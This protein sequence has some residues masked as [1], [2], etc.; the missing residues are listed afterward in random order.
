MRVQTTLVLLYMT[1][2]GSSHSI[3][4][5]ANTQQYQVVA[6]LI[7][8]AMM[9][10]VYCCYWSIYNNIILTCKKKDKCAPKM[11]A[12]PPMNVPIQASSIVATPLMIVE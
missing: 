7:M 12:V 1:S 3:A 9:V 4:L 8:N 2:M 6:T 5:N 10:C 11:C